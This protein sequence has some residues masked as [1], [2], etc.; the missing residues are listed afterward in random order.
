MLLE[1]TITVDLG[2]SSYD[3]VVGYGHLAS[4]PHRLRAI[5]GSNSIFVIT[6]SRVGPLHGPR[7]VGTLK[8]GG[9]VD[10]HLEAVPEGEASK[11]IE[12]WDHLLGCL[13][14]FMEGRQEKPLILNLGGGMVGDLG[15]FAAATYTRGCPYVQVPTSLMAMVDSSLG[16]K[17]GI[18]YRTAKN[19]IGSF[20][21]PRL[22]FV[23][24]AYL[25]TLD[26][27]E[28]RSGLAEVVKYGVIKD[29][30]LFDFTETHRQK[31]LALDAATIFHVITRSLEIK[32]RAVEQDPLDNKGVRIILNYGH[33]IG[34]AVEAAS[35]YVYKHGEA[36]GIGMVGANFLACQLGLL[37]RDKALRISSLLQALGLPVAAPGLDPSRVAG[38]LIHDKKFT[39]R[40]NRFVLPTDIGVVKT[41]SGIDDSLV[42][43]AIR[44]VTQQT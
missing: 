43:E 9:F 12:T 34:H 26:M 31:L 2:P 23:D 30:A 10:V 40:A 17:V 25:A 19:I 32:A 41:V 44:H 13:H 16:G 7:L 21:Q 33:T 8:D 24:I 11:S 35:E 14:T 6:D 3:A 42:Q 38:L 18:D 5:S 22:V 4:L 1:K 27:R 20:Y 37:G 39:G 29:G 28:V 36:V 15:G